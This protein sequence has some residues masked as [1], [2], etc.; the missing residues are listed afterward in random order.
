ML[1]LYPKIRLGGLHRF[2]TVAAAVLIHLFRG[3]VP[4][5]A[6]PA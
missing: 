1:W 6:A 3:R 4:P 2:S 5:A